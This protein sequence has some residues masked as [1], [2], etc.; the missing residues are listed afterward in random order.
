MNSEFNVLPHGLKTS[1]AAF[2]RVMAQNFAENMYKDVVVYMDDICTYSKNFK[3]GLQA[4]EKTFK[5]L[6]NLNLKLKTEKCEFLEKEIQLLGHKISNQGIKTLEKNI[7]AIIRFQRPKMRKHIKRFLG[8]CGYYRKFIKDFSRKVV[9]LN[10][11]SKG[12]LTDC[13]PVHW[14][15]DCEREFQ[16]MKTALTSPSVLALFREGCENRMELDASA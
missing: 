6:Q 3:G 11:L 8:S 5:V 12:D 9:H 16:N 10:E 15:E 4:L 14:T 13:M 2:S 7:E 1:L